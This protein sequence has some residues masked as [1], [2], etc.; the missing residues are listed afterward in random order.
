MLAGNIKPA[1][2]RA[3]IA[4]FRHDAT[5]VRHHFGAEFVHFR[6]RR[7]LEIERQVNFVLQAAHIIIAN[8]S[9]ILAQMRGDAVSARGRHQSSGPHRVRVVAAARIPDGRH[10]VDID[11][12]PERRFR[13]F[14]HYWLIPRLPGLTGGVSFK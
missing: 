11:A 4:V 7:H 1:L 5:G 6:R 12:E 3:F 8:V 2:G 14:G 10:M 13:L 9:A